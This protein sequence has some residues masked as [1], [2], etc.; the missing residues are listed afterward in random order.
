[1]LMGHDV[2][3]GGEIYRSISDGKFQGVTVFQTT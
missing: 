1:M 2:R 3:M